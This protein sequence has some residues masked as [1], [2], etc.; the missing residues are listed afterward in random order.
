MTLVFV[1]AWDAN[2]VNQ[3]TNP[4]GCQRFPGHAA[5]PRYPGIKGCY[6]DDLISATAGRVY[7]GALSTSRRA[8]SDPWQARRRVVL[9]INAMHMLPARYL[10]SLHD[11]TFA[12][13]PS[14]TEISLA[15]LGRAV[16]MEE[17]RLAKQAD[18]GP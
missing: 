9:I 15:W 7:R 4:A 14:D 5:M 11:C 3:S 10:S 8:E 16:R 6:A 18:A 13:S 17:C 1:S 2:P 12:P